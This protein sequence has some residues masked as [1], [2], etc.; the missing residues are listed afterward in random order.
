MHE[1]IRWVFCGFG[2][3]LFIAGFFVIRFRVRLAEQ[4]QAQNEK[5]A[6]FKSGLFG[7]GRATPRQQLI[8]GI[9]F[10]VFGPAFAVLSFFGDWS[11]F[12]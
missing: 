4:Q 5:M 8:L 12:G 9:F 1:I 10:I 3:L 2:V 7:S 6:L 11:R